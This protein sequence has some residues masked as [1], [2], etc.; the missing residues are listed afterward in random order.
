M[1]GGKGL[2]DSWDSL[3][4]KRCTLLGTG[5]I[6]RW[7][8]R[9]LKIFGC[10]V[11]G[12][13]LKPVETIP[14]NFDDI[15]LELNAALEGSELVFISLPLTKETKGMFDAGVISRMA[16]KF[17]VNV[18]RGEVVEEEALYNALKTGLLKG[19]GLDVWYT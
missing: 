14:E 4:G 8:A 3:A 7:I 6:G 19:A 17:L 9:F 13:K 16:G 2:A 12:F 18:G 11:I 5:E 15:T 10:E 1:W